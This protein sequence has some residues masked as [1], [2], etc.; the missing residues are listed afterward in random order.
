MTKFSTIFPAGSPLYEN[1]VIS[2]IGVED[3]VGSLSYTFKRVIKVLPTQYSLEDIG[4]KIPTNLS[5]LGNPGLAASFAMAFLNT[6]TELEPT[7]EESTGELEEESETAATTTTTVGTGT[8]A[9]GTPATGTAAV[10]V[11]PVVTVTS[12]VTGK[13]Q[14]N[15]STQRP[16]ETTT[17][18]KAKLAEAVST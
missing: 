6:I 8:T 13:Q 14:Q 1:T 9:T 15:T 10:T 7:S 3:A 11:P 5:A 17:Q 18:S 2:C 16:I 4:S 12:A